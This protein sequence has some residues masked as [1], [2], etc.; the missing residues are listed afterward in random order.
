VGAIGF[1]LCGIFGYS[2]FFP[3]D[4]EQTNWATEQSACS[5]FWGGWAFLIGSIV[6]WWEAVQPAQGTT[7]PQ[8]EDEGAVDRNE[9][10]PK[11]DVGARK[12]V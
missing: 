8:S 3:S 11:D 10:N 5:T 9:E 12:D 4:P 6:Q 1:T 7:R 2:R